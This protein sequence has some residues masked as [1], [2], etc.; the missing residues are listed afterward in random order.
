MPAFRMI[1]VYGCPFTCSTIDCH[2]YAVAL[3]R[4]ETDDG[5]AYLAFCPQCWQEFR[6]AHRQA[7]RDLDVVT[8]RDGGDEC[9]VQ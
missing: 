5:C 3:C 6:H 2:R 4:N 7:E 9:E 1:K 8:R